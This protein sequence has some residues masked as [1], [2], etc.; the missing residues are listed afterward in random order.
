MGS[1]ASSAICFGCEYEAEH[2]F[3]WS[4][5][6]IQAWWR[7]V[8][9]F[10]PIRDIYDR[11]GEYI[12]GVPPPEDVKRDYF[13]ERD[14]WDIDHPLPVELYYCGCPDYG[15]TVIAVPGTAIGA[16]WE[17]SV[18]FEPNELVVDPERLRM[19]GAFV[20]QY[21][22]SSKTFRWRLLTYAY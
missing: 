10:E 17:G 20:K 18:T 11:Y 21:C 13:L 16:T 8:S 19:A 3:P 14:H 22:G 4:N 5:S 6:D 1:C 7:G 9:G 15:E 2:T 12:G